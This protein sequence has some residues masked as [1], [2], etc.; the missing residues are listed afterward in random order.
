[1]LRFF[2]LDFLNFKVNSFG[3]KMPGN[4][5]RMP[6]KENWNYKIEV[7]PKIT[8]FDTSTYKHK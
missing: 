5:S 8:N 6:K 2:H 4:R 7:D 1:M 3:L